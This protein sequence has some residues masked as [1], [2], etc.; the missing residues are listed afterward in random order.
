M[1][2]RKSSRTTSLGHSWCWV[3]HPYRLWIARHTYLGA[4]RRCHSR[5]GVL[6]L[7]ELLTKDQVR[8]IACDDGGSRKD[9]RP[10]HQ[11]GRLAISQCF[12]FDFFCVLLCFFAMALLLDV[13]LSSHS[14]ALQVNAE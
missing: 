3:R 9:K 6:F 7:V 13:P 4:R 8:R 1:E 2:V 5:W 14:G 12:Y 10:N 11:S